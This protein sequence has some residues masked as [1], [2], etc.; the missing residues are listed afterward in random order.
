MN[1]IEQIKEYIP[2]IISRFPCIQVMYVF[3]SYASHTERP[4]SDVDIAIFA[5]DSADVMTD[6][7]LGAF[8]EEKL[9]KQIDI[10]VMQ[11]VSPI[12]QF[13]VLSNKIRIYERDS[14][15]RAKLECLSVRFYYD[16]CYVQEQ[17]ARNRRQHG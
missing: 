16:A 4:D 11:K 15:L 13:Q 10:V 5:D 8:L 12:V 1:I 14:E 7:R 17:R 3:G 9:H 2:E 6:L